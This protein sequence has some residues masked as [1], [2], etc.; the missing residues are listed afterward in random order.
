MLE[1]DEKTF[2]IR[3]GAKRFTP[4]K[5]NIEERKSHSKKKEVKNKDEKEKKR[6]S[7]EKTQILFLAPDREN[8]LRKKKFAEK[9][10]SF[11]ELCLFYMIFIPFL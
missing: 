10:Q 3:Q 4:D 5:E 9:K 11:P 1:H 2:S 6:L 8:F 7:Y